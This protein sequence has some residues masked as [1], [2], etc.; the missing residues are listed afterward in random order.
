MPGTQIAKRDAA[1]NG[2]ANT[3]AAMSDPGN[4][5]DLY[6]SIIFH[7]WAHHR[8]CGSQ[9]CALCVEGY[10]VYNEE[11]ERMLEDGVLNDE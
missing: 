7:L 6:R 3:E 8:N 10:R 2:N 5:L 11:Y 4:L 1:P 9:R